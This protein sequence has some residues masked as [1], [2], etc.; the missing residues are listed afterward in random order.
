MGDEGDKGLGG[1]FGTLVK[2]IGSTLLENLESQMRVRVGEQLGSPNLRERAE[3]AEKLR[4]ALSA[5][6]LDIP[7]AQ[8]EPLDR[9][10]TRALE[11]ADTKDLLAALKELAEGNDWPGLK[12]LLFVQ[13]VSPHPGVKLELGPSV[14][15][16]ELQL[17]NPDS[18]S[19]VASHLHLVTDEPDGDDTPTAP[20]A[21]DDEREPSDD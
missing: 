17:G 11:T 3:A 4:A 9:G 5:P 10:L 18:V 19:D 16:G 1:L 15:F 6:H 14:T 2:A 13:M 21:G 8:L 12:R 20:E 7:S